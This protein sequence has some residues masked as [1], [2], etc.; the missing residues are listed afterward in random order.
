MTIHLQ[1]L[2][3][4]LIKVYDWHKMPGVK[5]F[6]ESVPVLQQLRAAGYKIGLLTNSYFP[7]WVREVEMRAYGLWEYFDV[8]I[9]SGDTG[10]QKPHRWPATEQW[11]H[12]QL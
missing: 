9:T 6:P 10:W 5:V 2:L 1:R 7:M 11:R 12:R 8:C 4:Q 3:V